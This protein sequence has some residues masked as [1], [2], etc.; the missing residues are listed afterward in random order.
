MVQCGRA[1]YPLPP[2]LGRAARHTTTDTKKHSLPYSM[3]QGS[4]IIV[5]LVSVGLEGY[6]DWSYVTPVA[7]VGQR[8][9]GLGSCTSSHDLH[10]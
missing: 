5:V 2:Q 8:M 7:M 9:G 4:Q 10:E 6:C 3:S 1:G